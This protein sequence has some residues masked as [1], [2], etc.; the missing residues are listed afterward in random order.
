MGGGW[1][2]VPKC[3]ARVAAVMCDLLSKSPGCIGPL[4]CWAKSTI[5]CPPD[6][7]QGGVATVRRVVSGQRPGQRDHGRHQGWR[8]L[9]GGVDMRKSAYLKQCKRLHPGSPAPPT[10]RR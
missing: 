6:L 7:Q 10:P 4:L 8:G 9:E 3:A 2:A 5:T 1:G